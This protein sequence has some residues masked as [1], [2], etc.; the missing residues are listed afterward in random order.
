M[1]NIALKAENISK[2]YRLGQINNGTLYADIQSWFARK[3]GKEDPHAKIGFDSAQSDKDGFWALKD[4]NFEI[5]QG[6]RV[7]IIGRNGAGK[8]TLLKVISEIT[9]PTTGNI[10]I[11]GRVASLLEVGTGFHPEMTGR[12]NIYMNGAILGMKKT[13]ITRQLD[14]II[15]FAEIEKYIDTPVKRYSSGMYVRLAFAVAAHLQSEILIADEVL[16]VGD[17]QFQK[18][19]IG[20]MS[21]LS[22]SEGR[23][24]LFVS[25]QMNAVKSLCKSG[26]VLE[27]G[28][29]IKQGEIEDSI[30]FYQR[31]LFAQEK[32]EDLSEYDNEFFNL[33]EFEIVD[34][35]GKIVDDVMLN[36]EQYYVKIKFDLKKI[37]TGFCLGYSLYDK[38][39]NVIYW[40]YPT[41][42]FNMYHEPQLGENIFFG[43]IPKNFV[44][45]DE[46][47]IYIQGGVH[48]QQWCINPAEKAPRKKIK[49][50]GGLSDSP[51]WTMKRPG[52]C[53]PILKWK[54]VKGDAINVF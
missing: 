11:K 41:D 33:L 47:Y 51:F 32:N 36:N 26:I 16:A 43:E 9:T 4:I 48:F 37:H 50:Q 19:A 40:S 23:T 21:D 14:E 5:K 42:D 25:H 8:S 3:L 49:I 6:D 17:A 45:E 38:E 1:G 10:Y 30:S 2:Y 29:I 34:A 15:D 54:L 27:C 39:G 18:K 52:V 24:I 22:T 7:G 28:K 35:D 31:D 13:E 12:E 20:K 44:N 46:Y 53:A